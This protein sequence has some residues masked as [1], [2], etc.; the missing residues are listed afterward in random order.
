MHYMIEACR[1]KAGARYWPD[2]AW[3]IHLASK[4]DAYGLPW[5]QGQVLAADSARRGGLCLCFVG[6]T[7]LFSLLLPL[8]VLPMVVQGCIEV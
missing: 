7:A 4:T 2:S 8:Q 5:L 1:S 3:A 6:C